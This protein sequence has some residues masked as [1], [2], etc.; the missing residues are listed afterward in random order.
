MDG[1][2][3]K[4]ILVGRSKRYLMSAQL[5][6]AIGTA[7]IRPQQMTHTTSMRGA[8]TVTKDSQKQI[9]PIMSSIVGTLMGSPVAD[10][11]AAPYDLDGPRGTLSIRP[12]KLDVSFGIGTSAHETLWLCPTWGSGG[13]NWMEGP[14]DCESSSCRSWKW[15]GPRIVSLSE[16]L[17]A[18][19]ALS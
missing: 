10:E 13:V 16:P 6:L 18:W 19:N 3:Q 8:I 14:R 2:E 4:R 12:S 17:W 7:M 9:R 5:S 1:A 15:E 11:Y